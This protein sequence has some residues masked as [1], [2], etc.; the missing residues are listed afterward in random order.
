MLKALRE[1]RRA[2]AELAR[3]QAL[4]KAA[5]RLT[6]YAEDEG[7]WPHLGPVVEGLLAAGEPVCYLTSSATD[8]ILGRDA[9]GLSAFNI[10][11]GTAR[12]MAFTGLDSAVHLMTMP[13]LDSFHIKRSSAARVHYVYLFHSIVSAHMIYRPRAFD[14]FDTV[15]CVGPHHVAELEAGD[16]AAGRRRALVPHG[17]ARLDALLAERPEP[18][19]RDG[20]PTRVLL[21]PSWGPEGL[22]ERH[23][24]A[25]VAALLAAG[26]HVT[27]RPHP[28]TGRRDPA[29]IAALR[30]RFEGTS[31][32]VFEDD[33]RAR[34]SLYRSDVMISDWSGAAFEYALGLERPVVFVDVPKKVND[35]SWQSLGPTP[36]EIAMRERLGA[37]VSPERPAETV[38]AIEDLLARREDFVEGL[39][40]ARRELIFHPGR[41]AEAAVAA[42][43][44]CLAGADPIAAARQAGG[45]DRAGEEAEAEEE[46]RPT[47]A[48][49]AASLRAELEGAAGDV[50]VGARAF[51][52][53][54]RLVELS[55][56]LDLS[57]ELSPEVLIDLDKLAR[58]VH[59]AARLRAVYRRG[60]WGRIKGSKALAG[61]GRRL[62]LAT[63]L[64]AGA[65]GRLAPGLRMKC[66]NAA[67]RLADRLE[68]A[69]VVRPGPLTRSCREQLQALSREPF[70]VGGAVWSA[71]AAE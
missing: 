65:A 69:G 41:S 45:S 53:A 25:F 5:R 68:R 3:F 48:V 35:P 18:A 28:M 14:A 12:T 38:A 19:P 24:E 11:T 20:R 55:A 27:V 1:G 50:E 17:Y 51:D 13:D 59:L 49:A 23:G 31:G 6:V 9:E 63:L 52:L 58:K 67:L 37:V 2:L 43:R 10:G 61:P 29:V 56:A 8:P 16:R 66:L 40:A 46:P 36:V 54:A 22:I 62:A 70:R 30:R 39:R 7:S 33:M 44:A 15:L 57:E 26:L 21:A 71:E 42:I 4:P 32:F 60:S 47:L 64:Q 34:D